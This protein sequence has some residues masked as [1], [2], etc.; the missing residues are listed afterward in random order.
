M[1]QLLLTARPAPLSAL[2]TGASG[3]LGSL[4]CATL[5]HRTQAKI[6][7]PVRSK[8]NLD[9][10]RQS[11]SDEMRALNMGADEIVEAMPRLS[12]CPLPD[13]MDVVAL[14][15]LSSAAN[16]DVIVH[17]AGSVD[18]FDTAVLDEVNVR[19]TEHLLQVAKTV[20]ARM[21][22]IST[23]FSSGYCDGV[24]G[25]RLHAAPAKD[26]TDYT[27]SK[28]QAEAMVADSGVP[29]L[30]LR[31]SIVVG[32]SH[33]GRY[34]GKPWGAYQFYA[35]AERLLLDNYHADLHVVAPAVPVCALHQDAF[36]QGCLA[37]LLWVAD[38]G[39]V[40]VVSS[41]A[42]LPTMRDVLD[43]WLEYLVPYERV[44]VY[45]RL[46]QVQMA[47]LSRRQRMMAEF[48]AVNTEIATH[49]WNFESTTMDE[50]RP[51]M[52]FVDA[53]QASLKMCLTAWL[54][55]SERVN[56]HRIAHAARQNTKTELIM[57]G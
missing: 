38:G 57:A 47:A 5:L 46:D 40:H 26:P 36:Q 31:P 41:S 48:S 49:S 19:F 34:A 3:L 44:F 56:A 10:L 9:A 23:A 35:A 52:Q 12:I 15:A 2:V 14:T 33:T 29:F 8:H 7:A 21:V 13:V 1:S 16:V 11:I 25:E 45:D 4:L 51:H 24:I 50:L 18:Y 37:A 6:I 43:G 39:I 20:G 54:Q 30:I 22:F 42:G 32:H 28:R 17:A 53:T 55:R 27:R